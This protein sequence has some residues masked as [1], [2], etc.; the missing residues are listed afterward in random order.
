MTLRRSRASS[1]KTAEPDRRGAGNPARA[2]PVLDR[3]RPTLELTLLAFGDTVC[4]AQSGAA[5]R[6]R[7]GGVMEQVRR[8][9]S[10]R[11]SLLA[12]AIL[13]SVL[14]P[15]VRTVPAQAVNTLRW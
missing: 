14:A 15:L 7:M 12:A 10:A 6:D 3:R 5:R 13:A 4:D 8:T 1:P 11:R 9:L 2:H